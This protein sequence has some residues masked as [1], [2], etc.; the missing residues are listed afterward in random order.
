MDLVQEDEL[1][2][3]CQ[4]GLHVEAEIKYLFLKIHHLGHLTT[5][6][7]ILNLFYQHGARP[8]RQEI[9]IK[10]VHK[11]ARLLKGKMDGV[12]KNSRAEHAF[13]PGNEIPTNEALW[14]T[15]CKSITNSISYQ[16]T[17]SKRQETS[18]IG[19]TFLELQ[20]KKY[21]KQEVRRKGFKS[22]ALKEETEKN[23]T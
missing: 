13:N 2:C 7:Q 20:M 4:P 5:Q 8:S 21:Q 17:I 3:L 6:T 23:R 16:P 22:A 18:I 11:P 19:I 10:Y 12:N 15:Q 9:H 1:S 14:Q